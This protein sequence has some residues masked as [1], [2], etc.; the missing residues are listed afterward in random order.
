MT[1][2]Y[3]LICLTVLATL[4]CLCIRCCGSNAQGGIKSKTRVFSAK[5]GAFAS[6]L[7]KSRWIIGIRKFH[8][9]VI[10]ILR[11]LWDR[12]KNSKPARA[13]RKSD[14]LAAFAYCVV[15]IRDK[16][17]ELETT[18]DR[19]VTEL[20]RK[21]MHSRVVTAVTNVKP[22]KAMLAFSPGRW[23]Q[24]R[25]ILQ[26]YAASPLASH[27]G[28]KN[29]TCLVYFGIVFLMLCLRSIVCG[30]DLINYEFAFY[31]IP[32]QLKDATYSS[33]LYGFEIGFVALSL[34]V[35]FIF[36]HFRVFLILLA[37]I[38]WL[39]VYVLF[40]RESKNQLLSIAIFLTLGMMSLY[41]SA[42]RQVVAMA[43]AVPAYYYAK[44]KRFWP[45]VAI[46]L[47]AT[48]FH[49][50]SA[51]M[52]LI[53]PAFC[54]KLRNRQIYWLVPALAL[55]FLLIRP[56]FTVLLILIGK[57]G[58]LES[59]GAYGVLTLLFAFVLY[60]FIVPDESKAT[61][62][63]FALRNILVL[64]LVMQMFAPLHTLAMRMNYYFLLFV[65]IAVSQV[66]PIAREG[67]Q[68]IAKLA[69]VVMTV[70]FVANYVLTIKP[71]DI[72]AV[73]PYVPFWK[74]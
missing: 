44:K 42:M 23:I 52:L 53:Y 4:S 47:V 57:T 58:E 61:E 18:T 51:I 24:N 11:L 60:A 5:Y 41:F 34:I 62:D 65:P 9:Y 22:V 12:L 70:F 66:Q 72:L 28:T 2:Y 56:V 35:E 17:I 20:V 16:I 21:V 38:S 63:F 69:D 1:I 54:I 73:Y 55:L 31:Y 68:K 50:S 3:I 64:A 37:C 29:Y 10:A 74:G 59:T 45:F 30:C 15:V 67:F 32:K 43:F 7:R 39:P 27:M 48:L 13:I 46:V 8:I 33:Q 19:K 71:G 49:T 26:R 25:K 36:R 6:R 14:T 40:K